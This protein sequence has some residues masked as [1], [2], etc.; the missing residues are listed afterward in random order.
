M[1]AGFLCSLFLCFGR[2]GCLPIC[3]VLVGGGWRLITALVLILL[4]LTS[5]TQQSAVHTADTVSGEFGAIALGI[6]S[7]APSPSSLL[8]D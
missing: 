4:V 7:A 3:L 8:P 6:V 1:A 5:E 2:I